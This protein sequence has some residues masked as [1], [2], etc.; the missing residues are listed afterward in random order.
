MKPTE[1]QRAGD[2]DI[3][4]FEVGGQ[5]F[6]TDPLDVVR[7]DRL[8]DEVPLARVLASSGFSTRTLVVR[9]ASGEA[10]VP[11]DKVLGVRR[12]SQDVLRPVPAYLKAAHPELASELLGVVLE[13]GTGPV[14]VLD[15]K[16][17][18]ARAKAPAGAGTTEA[19]G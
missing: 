14:L 12:L 18:S 3:F 6:G 16:R 19:H 15:L 10:Q 5:T 8:R 1:K 13:E 4:F 7:V 9:A 17:V 11:V 2:C